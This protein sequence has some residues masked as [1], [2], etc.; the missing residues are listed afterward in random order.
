MIRVVLRMYTRFD[1]TGCKGPSTELR[2]GEIKYTYREKLD[3]SRETQ[4]GQP[5]I[6]PVQ[7]PQKHLKSTWRIWGAKY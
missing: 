7:V 2:Q 4:S 6:I 5:C 1:K 3:C